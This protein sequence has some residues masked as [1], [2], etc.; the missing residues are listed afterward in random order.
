M[1][2]A[3]LPFPVDLQWYEA[4]DLDTYPRAVVPVL[5]V[6]PASAAADAASGTVTLL[7]AV[8]ENGSVH[9]AGIVNADPAGFFEA[10][11]LEAAHRA[12]FAAGQKDGHSV[13][14]KIIVKLHFAPE[15][16]ADR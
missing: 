12:R 6:Y 3:D 7:V 1:P 2:K 4:R 5:P 15:G 14:A 11:A 16:R 8:D 13:R 9:E 10:A